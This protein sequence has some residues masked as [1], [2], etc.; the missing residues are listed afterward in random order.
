MGR[1][2]NASEEIVSFYCHGYNNVMSAASLHLDVAA[3]RFGCWRLP[4]SRRAAAHRARKLFIFN[5]KL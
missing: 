1:R 5:V 3:R 2:D 4:A